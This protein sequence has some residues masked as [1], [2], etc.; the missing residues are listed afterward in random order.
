MVGPE[1]K[2]QERQGG[3]LF[4]FTG[5]ALVANVLSTKTTNKTILVSTVSQT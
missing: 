3:E 2:T 5:F 4:M 1:D